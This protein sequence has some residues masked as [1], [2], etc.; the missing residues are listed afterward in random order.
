MS[1]VDLQTMSDEQLTAGLRA[2]KI[3]YFEAIYVRYSSRL[4]SSAY[5]ILRNKEA[6]EDLIQ[7][8]F[9][10]LWQKKELLNIIKLKSYLYTSARNNALLVLR[11]GKVTLDLDVIKMLIDDYATDDLLLQKE[12]TANLQRKIK[13]LPAKCREIFVLSRQEQ[14]SHKEIA[15]RLNI[16][17]K[18]VENQITTAL[19]RLKFLLVDF[20]ILLLLSHFL[21]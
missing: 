19:K 20:T 5:N 14:L 9:I 7:D 17:I 18:T 1:R 10:D 2:G 21:W 6:C 13:T 4:Y 15:A 12:I 11:S 3:D 16:S 8:L